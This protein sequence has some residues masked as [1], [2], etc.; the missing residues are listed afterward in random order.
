M[1]PRGWDAVLKTLLVLG[2]YFFHCCP[3]L[4]PK[5]SNMTGLW[6]MC[7]ELRV[8]WN[9][10]RYFQVGVPWP[11]GCLLL[12]CCAQHLIPAIPFQSTSTQRIRCLRHLHFTDE[13]TEAPRHYG[14]PHSRWESVVQLQVG[15]ISVWRHSQDCLGFCFLLFNKTNNLTVLV[16]VMHL[17]YK[18]F[19]PSKKHTEEGK[20]IHLI[21]H[22]PENRIN[23]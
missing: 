12:G 16:E 3:L 5:S 20:I 19:K 10:W 7:C 14:L 2:E 18:K 6:P 15:Q 21:S 13:K 23:I 8:S 22:Y 17:C 1:L 11:V 9:F 4:L